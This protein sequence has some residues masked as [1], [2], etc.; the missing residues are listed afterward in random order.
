[1]STIF[2]SYRR[3]DLAWAGWLA[4][5]LQRDFAIFFDTDPDS[6]A[7]GAPW[8]PALRNA[9]QECRVAL[10]VIG[11]EWTS[12]KNLERLRSTDDC[13][14]KELLALLQRGSDIRMVPVTVGGAKLPPAEMLPDDLQALRSYQTC[15]LSSSTP[16]R[17]ATEVEDLARSL[18]HWLS[19]QAVRPRPRP[20]PGLLP[21]LCDRIPQEAAL[22]KHIRLTAG[23]RISHCITHGHKFEGH[24]WFLKRQLHNHVLED[25]FD[26]RDTG[27]DVH[28]LKWNRED[29]KAG[30]YRELLWQT[31][32]RNMRGR[33]TTDIVLQALLKA[34]KPQILVLQVTWADC[35]QCGPALLSRL[36]EAWHELFTSDNGQ[37]RVIP[38]RPLLLWINV[39][40]NMPEQ[41]VDAAGIEGVLPRLS[42]ISEADIAE[43]S[44]DA[45]VAPHVT[46]QELLFLKI[47]EDPRF[48][49]PDGSVHMMHFADAVQEILNRR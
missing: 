37:D 1:M 45:E 41:Q 44:N 3:G 38:E 36:I 49:L 10:V 2:F 29:A 34:P 8:N 13:V 11:P 42:S 31:L 22:D 28:F 9:L 27:I 24:D 25:L 46:G 35:Q 39:S 18:K 14:R 21:Y 19:S 15:A 5:I 40:Y 4:Y 23:G 48:C 26:S 6:I 12:Q 33:P 43:W 47:L 32:K 20:A 17:W 30:K 7:P 16:R